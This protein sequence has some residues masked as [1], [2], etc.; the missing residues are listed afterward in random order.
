MPKVKQPNSSK[1]R[2]SYTAWIS[3]WVYLNT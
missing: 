2:N 1:V 3:F